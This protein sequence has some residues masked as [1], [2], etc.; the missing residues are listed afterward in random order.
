VPGPAALTSSVVAPAGS[1]PAAADTRC[2]HCGEALPGAGAPHARIDGR[3]R[4]FCCTGCAAAARWID[5]AALGDYYRLRERE[6]GRVDPGLD[7]SATIDDG[8]WDRADLLAEHARAVPGGCEIVVLTDGMRCAAC[9]WLIDR[10][11][12]RAP[13]VSEIAANALTGRIRIVWDPARVALSALIGRLRALGYGVSLAT[14]EARER[15]RRAE[16]RRWMLRLGIAALGTMQAMMFAEAL[17]L[18]FSRQMPEPTRDFFRWITFLVSTPVVFYSGWPFIAGM[19]RE[20]RGRRLGMDT[21]IAGSTLLAYVAS[22]AET[23]RGGAHVWYDA[24]V[25]FVFLLLTA[26][27]F[28]ARA[29]GIAS[30]QVDAMARARPALCLRE[31]AGGADADGARAALE[32][33]PPAALSPGDVVRVA[34]GEAMPADGVLL[35][36]AAAFDESLLS[37]E[38]RA[39]EKAAGAEVYAGSH[40]RERP[41]RLRIVRS[42]A[43]TRLSQLT[44]LVERAQAQRPA[45][46][47]VTERIGMAFTALLLIAA[48]ATYAW[49]RVHDPARAFEVALAVLVVSCPCALSLAVPAA[50]TAAHGALAKLGVLALRPDALQTLARVDR[51]VFDKT[52]TLGAR[53]L[54][55][56][57][58]EILRGRDMPGLDAQA[59]LRIA[60]ALEEGSGHPLA[61]AFPPATARAVVATQR[62]S[63]TGRGVGGC[64]DGR[65]W[66]LGRGDW[67]APLDARAAAGANA[68]PIRNDTRDDTHDVALDD[69]LWLGDGERGYARFVLREAPRDDAQA[70]VAALAAQGIAVSLCSGDAAPAVVRMAEAVGIATR[71]ARQSPED[72]LAYVRAR[73]AAGEVVAMVGDG[74]NDAPVLAGA[75]VSLALADGAA[76][77]QRA[78]DLVIVGGALIR[79]PQAV[80][81]ARRTRRIVRENLA[82]ALGYNLVALPLAAMGLVTPWLAAI[83]MSLSSLLVTLNALRLL[84]TPPTMSATGAA[85]DA[86]PHAQAR[87]RVEDP[88]RARADERARGIGKTATPAVPQAVPDTGA[89]ARA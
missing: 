3:V 50:L 47:Q 27:L 7:G 44:R 52:G 73:Q 33:V 16:S 82:W 36:D 13:G 26:R 4:A 61:A 29:R 74:I 59:A 55:L 43:D 71:H 28:E 41:A 48:A 53:T 42:G 83:G 81:L 69:A 65:I 21:L 8:V 67:A 30:A 38:S 2:F 22:L 84:R 88:L 79:V 34:V 60:A 45:L 19:L 10:A 85:A 9:A 32:R 75:D 80:A 37:G 12:S 89:G 31:L 62:R 77:A 87:G 46:A 56:A 76:L 54:V 78:A 72:K 39:V 24:A 40:C 6:A 14:G 70:A 25:M 11:L 5:E 68:T 23:V 49:W 66:R 51:V 86:Q 35:D 1:A 17:Y 63:E 58:V 64:I 57:Q 18:D 20:L 15:A